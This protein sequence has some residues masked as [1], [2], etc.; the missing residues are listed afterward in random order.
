MNFLFRSL[1]GWY[2]NLLRNPQLRWPTI[3]GTLVY[4]LSPI[5]LAPDLLPLAGQIDDVALIIL[6]VSEIS[7][8]LGEWGQS[9]QTPQESQTRQEGDRSVG[10]SAKTIDVDAVSL[11]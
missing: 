8:M 9:W 7:R 10:S 1:G 11:D 6:L 5:D 2:R 3:L 4:V